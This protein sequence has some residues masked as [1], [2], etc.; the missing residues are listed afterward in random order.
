MDRDLPL[1]AY[2]CSVSDESLC[3]LP[4]GLSYLYDID[5][6]CYVHGKTIPPLPTSSPE[7]QE[8]RPNVVQTFWDTQRPKVA[9]I[10][11]DRASRSWV[12]KYDS[13]LQ[14]ESHVLLWKY[15]RMLM[16]FDQSPNMDHL[17]FY[18]HWRDIFGGD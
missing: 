11:H 10:N 2:L 13:I 8:A 3:H 6:L 5:V 15:S 1:P 18:V 14:E 4:S 9:S 12:I 17:S 7:W 16:N